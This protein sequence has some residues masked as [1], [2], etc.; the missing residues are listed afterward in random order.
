MKIRNATIEDIDQLSSL[1]DSYRV[2]YRKPSDKKAAT[3]F[4]KER[5]QQADSEIF[6]AA[7]QNELKGFV[8]LYP[9]FSSTK[10]CKMWLL[11]DLFVDQKSRG[12][13]ISKKLIEQAKELVKTS[14]A[15]TMFLET[16]KTNKIGNQL[17]PVTGF[18]LNEESNYY[19]WELPENK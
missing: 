12:Q 1:F 17:Y 10:M 19:E 16:E 18:K 4:L 15:K 2:F 6:V 7:D 3:E 8:Q 5:L 14:G 13:G 9:L 11:N